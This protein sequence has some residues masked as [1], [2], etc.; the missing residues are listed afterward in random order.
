MCRLINDEIGIKLFTFETCGYERDKDGNLTQESW[1]SIDKIG[2]YFYRENQGERKRYAEVRLVGELSDEIK[3]LNERMKVASAPQ[4]YGAN[5]TPHMITLAKN[6]NERSSITK[7][8]AHNNF[9]NTI[10]GFLYNH[11]LNIY[12]ALTYGEITQTVFDEMR[13]IVDN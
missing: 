11:I 2:R 7:Q 4:N 10:K 3:V 8:I 5:M 9:I 12:N 6:V 1:D 13:E